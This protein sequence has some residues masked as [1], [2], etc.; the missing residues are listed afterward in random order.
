MK[1]KYE[2]VKRTIAGE[3]FLVPVGEA[4]KHYSGLFALSEVG[5]FIWDKL[6]DAGTDADVVEAVLSEYE[7]D[8]ETAEAD[9]AE[10]L[11][12]LREMNII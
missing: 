9:T 2:F 1:I 3:T 5:A 8:R 11:G 4:V 12:K 7:V 6:E 10:F